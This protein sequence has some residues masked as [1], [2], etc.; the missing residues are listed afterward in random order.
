MVDHTEREINIEVGRYPE[1][2]ETGYIKGVGNV[3]DQ[4]EEQLMEK[5]ARERAPNEVK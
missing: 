2:L 3:W 4:E 5:R 1:K